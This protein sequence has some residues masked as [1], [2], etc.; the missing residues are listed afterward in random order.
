MSEDRIDHATTPRDPGL[1]DRA[2]IDALIAA[3]LPP[4][5]TGGIGAPLLLSRRP[6]GP[7]ARL[8]PFVAKAH[9]ADSD[10]A[11]LRTRLRLAAHPMLGEILLPPAGFGSDWAVLRSGRLITFWPYGTPLDPADHEVVPWGRAAALLAR[12][13]RI[14]LTHSANGT[15]LVSSHAGRE[16]TAA[17][18]DHSRADEPIP[19]VGRPDRVERA[20]DRLRAANGAANPRAAEVVQRAHAALPPLDF[21]RPVAH[22]ERPSVLVHGDFHLG[23]LVWT[24]APG[25]EGLRLI[26]VDDLGVGDP[27]WDLARLAGFFAAGILDSTVWE[28][29]LGAYRLAGG[30]AV[31]ERDEW[32]VLDAPAQAM[33]VHAAALGVAKAGL[34]GRELDEWDVALVDSCRRMTTPV[35]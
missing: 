10:I 4:H 15:A 23:Q 26:D 3:V 19:A 27:V 16:R 2:T 25:G 12:L 29:F 24:D 31:P 21:G 1:P 34:E 7:V 17:A 32:S 6:D 28:R 11:S 20:V 18:Q 35:S 9:A 22:G 33:V 13:H 8:G 14:P 5:P 30:I